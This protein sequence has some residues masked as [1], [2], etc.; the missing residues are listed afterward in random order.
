MAREDATLARASTATIP[1]THEPPS[2]PSSPG[3]GRHVMLSRRQRAALSLLAALVVLFGAL[4]PDRVAP[5]VY[6]TFAAIFTASAAI[7]LAALLT[8]RRPQVAP[9]LADEALPHYSLIVPLY[10]EADVA[11]E[12]VANLDRLDYPRDRLQAL[13]VL[14]ADDQ[15]T[16]AA[17][18]ALDLP[19]FIQVLV[20]PPGEPRTKPRA[21]NAALDRKS[22]V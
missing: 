7:R 1:F 10:R 6:W 5:C 3:A 16:Q 19:A 15:I 12:L 8:P 18:H 22:V 11:G 17:F 2:R 13:I 21:C 4:N 14:E 9:A 20:A